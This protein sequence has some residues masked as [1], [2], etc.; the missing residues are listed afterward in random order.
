MNLFEYI[1]F[2]GIGWF[3]GWIVFELL[4]LLAILVIKM[5]RRLLCK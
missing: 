4:K 5:I 3:L 2:G 1:L